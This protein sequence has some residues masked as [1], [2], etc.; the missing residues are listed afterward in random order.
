[1][2]EDTPPHDVPR[3]GESTEN[4]ASRTR[5][6]SI[7]LGSAV[8]VILCTGGI[9]VWRAESRTN[10]I[11]LDAAPKPVTATVA[12][13]ERF[14]ASRSYVG[15][16]EPWLVAS[17]GPQ[18]VSAYVDTVLVRPG[19]IVKQGEVLATLDCRDASAA[20]QAVASE[21][22]A[23]DARQRAAANEAAR[24]NTLLAQKFVSPNEA[25]QKTAQSLSQ[26]AELQAMRA[27]L[28]QKALEVNDCVLR[29]PFDGE[30]ATRTTDPGAFVRPGISI[31]SLVDRGTVRLVGDAPE[32]DFAVV[33][34]GRKATIEVA[35]T[36]THVVGT[37]SRRA[38]SADPSTRTVRFEIDLA[39]PE[40]A[41]PVDTTG[42][43][44]LD[45]GEPEPAT[46]IPLFAASVRGKKAT[47]FVVEGG[48]ARARTV[49][50][51]GEIGGKLYVDTSLAAGAIVVTEGRALLADGDRVDAKVVND[52]G[53]P[54]SPSAAQAPSLV[55]VKAT[56]SARPAPVVGDAPRR[57]VRP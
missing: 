16:L 20:N 40:R 4:A 36:R 1:M 10:K 41:I 48:V 55:E 42:V 53:A 6:V 11:A 22:R 50:V 56:T 43:V 2:S 34:P 5:T 33:A 31:V 17:I 57:E 47:L 18:L 35:A 38:P 21:A 28:T 25:E 32:I 19:A 49:D 14:Q 45:V 8:A 51:K 52:V 15:R 37:I 29:A 24:L 13:A 3:P 39:D 7:V 12:A 44:H 54:P 23:I 9:L 27:T 26:E 30:I 46:S